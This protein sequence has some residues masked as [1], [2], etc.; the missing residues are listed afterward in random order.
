MKVPKAACSAECPYCACRLWSLLSLVIVLNSSSLKF[1]A[2]SLP[3]MEDIFRH[4]SFKMGGFPKKRG[5]L[6]GVLI[7]RMIAYWD[8]DWGLPFLE[9]PISYKE[10]QHYGS[11]FP[12][13]TVV[14]SGTYYMLH[15]MLEFPVQEVSPLAYVHG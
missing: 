14:Q 11:R 1:Q 6:A 3:W 8:P 7:R 4:V 9:I 13:S 10:I 5:S 12:P 15:A 2:R